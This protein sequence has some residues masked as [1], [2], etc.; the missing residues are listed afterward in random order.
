VTPAPNKRVLVITIDPAEAAFRLRLGILAPLLAADGFTFD[1]RTRPGDFGARKRLIATAGDYAAVIVQRKLLD[2]SHARLL[3]RLAKRVIFDLDDAVMTQRR[4]VSRWSRWLKERRFRAT[5]AAADHVVAG[6]EHLAQAFRELGRP[7]TVL[8]TV[9]DPDHYAV[10]QH[11]ATDRPTLVWIGS[12]STLPYLR[13]W[14]PQ[15]E[16]AARRV[17]GLRLVT[18]ANDTVASDAMPV[19]HVPW[20]EAGEAA[21]LVRGDIGIAPTPADAWTAGKSG[22]K[23]VQYMAAGLPTIA[24]PVGANADILTDGV[25]GLLPETAEGW[26]DAIVQLAG[27]VPR[28][29]AMG[30]AARELVLSGYNLGRAADVWRR[31]LSGENL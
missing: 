24:S 10:K 9:V 14:M 29:R 28:R 8:P 22:F 12:G 6:N 2:P 18:I 11:A 23:I 1:Y 25:T 7:V 26:P 4:Q 20:S 21:A 13:Q 15:L 3:R 31:L 27:D 30:S 19:E 16:A 5:A 17:P